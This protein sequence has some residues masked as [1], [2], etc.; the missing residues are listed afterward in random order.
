V[1]ADAG[2]IEFW[3]NNVMR[4][5]IDSSGN[6][7]IG[8][9][10]TV[11]LDVSGDIK[12]SGNITGARFYAGSSSLTAAAG[13]HN[14]SSLTLGST[15]GDMVNNGYMFEVT[16]TSVCSMRSYA[17]RKASGSAASD[18]RFR[19]SCR[20]Q[21]ASDPSNDGGFIDFNTSGTV[22]VGKGPT[23]YLSFDT[24]GYA[25]FWYRV[26]FNGT[27]AIAK[28]TVTGSRGSNAALASLLT[29]LANYG[30]ITDS[31]T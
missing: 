25:T 8:T 17:Y 1:T 15:I 10:P 4:G 27:S 9:T 23:D 11:K 2:G 22:A 18:M 24:N 26:G 3:T 21:F 12:A 6:L 31:T 5:Q 13:Y 14:S 19:L 7:G 29:A 16:S 30:L 28:P 20:G